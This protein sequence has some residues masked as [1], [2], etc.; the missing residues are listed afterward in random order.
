M[1]DRGNDALGK[2]VAIAAQNLDYAIERVQADEKNKMT[3]RDKYLSERG[4]T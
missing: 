2:K 4:Y 3:E 1:A